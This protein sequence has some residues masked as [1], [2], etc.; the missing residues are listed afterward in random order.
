MTSVVSGFASSEADADGDA[1]GEADSE[2]G[3][4][5]DGEAEGD[6]E[7]DGELPE[8]ELPLLPQAVRRTPVKAVK[9]SVWAQLFFFIRTIP[10]TIG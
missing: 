3:A 4:E 8:F 1:G 5:A 7:G 2:A 6:A 9:R 10:S